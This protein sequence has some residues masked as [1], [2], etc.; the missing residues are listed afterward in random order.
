MAVEDPVLVFVVGCPRSGTT[1]VGELIGASKFVYNAKE[2]FLIDRV[3]SWG[4]ML[5]LSSSLAPV[6]VSRAEALVQELILSTTISAGRTHFVDH[7]PWHA[8]HAEDIWRLFPH[9]KIVHVIRHP[10]SVIAS[11]ERSY[12]AGYDWAGPTTDDR[13]ALWKLF[14][15]SIPIHTKGDL[16]K[17]IR[18]EDLCTDP[19]GV[20]RSLY[21]WIVLPWDSSVL[22]AFAYPHAPNPGIPFTLAT[23]DGTERTFYDPPPIPQSQVVMK[24]LRRTVIEQAA[25][26]GYQLGVR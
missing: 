12:V 16:I 11:L 4:E 6:F 24:K 23:T 21:N 19:V 3:H 5:A 10:A 2:S 25:M 26:F 20:A 22:D 18:Y 15:D 14:I 13:I 1:L 7:T 17:H 9:A 8:L